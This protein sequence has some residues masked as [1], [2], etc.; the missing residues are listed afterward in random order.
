VV[1]G[2]GLSDLHDPVLLLAADGILQALPVEIEEAA[3]V[4][5]CSLFGAFIKM[6]IPL[7]LPAS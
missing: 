7:S 4:D 3:I 1:A 2:A 5:G 6:A